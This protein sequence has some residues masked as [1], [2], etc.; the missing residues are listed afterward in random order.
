MAG[1]AQPMSQADY[2][3]GQ[4]AMAGQAS[5]LTR[6]VNDLNRARY[7]LTDDGDLPPDLVRRLL[8]YAYRLRGTAEEAWIYSLPPGTLVD[9]VTTA[10]ES[11][12]DC[13]DME[14]TSPHVAEELDKFPGSGQTECVLNCRCFLRT[15]DGQRCFTLD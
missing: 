15:A 4:A 6:L 5:F 2:Q 3:F 7:P 11:C 10:E 9:W 8:W 1:V 12:A 14:A 13:L